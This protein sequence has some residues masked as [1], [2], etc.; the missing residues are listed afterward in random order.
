MALRADIVSG[1][2]EIRWADGENGIAWGRHRTLSYGMH[3]RVADGVRA[4]FKG[5]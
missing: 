1:F 2:K 5:G 3:R 4:V